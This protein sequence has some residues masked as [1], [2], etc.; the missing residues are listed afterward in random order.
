MLDSVRW[1]V[2]ARE[3]ENADAEVRHRLKMAN[4]R[5]RMHR[6]EQDGT[7]CD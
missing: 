3:I 5:F 1:F 7:L 2:P 4:G 6:P